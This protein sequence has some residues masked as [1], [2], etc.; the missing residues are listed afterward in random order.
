M[1]DP[2][3]DEIDEALWDEACRRAEASRGDPRI[4]D[5]SIWQG[6][7][8]EYGA[9]GC[10]TRSQSGNRIPSYQAI[11][12]WGNGNVAGERKPGRPDGSRVLDDK[13][14]EIIPTTINRY[15]LNKNRPSISQLIRDVQTGCVSAGLKPPHRRTI[16]TGLEDIDLQK[17]AKRRG[18]I[19]VVKRTTAVPGMLAAS[20]PL[21]IVQVDH[22]KADIFVV[23]EETRLP[24]GTNTRLQD[25]NL[26]LRGRR[27][28]ASSCVRL[29]L[30]TLASSVVLMLP[31][32]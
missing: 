31:T 29:A 28:P 16:E 24:I 9:A 14:D 7:S 17:R 6:S 27:L 12:K 23:D 21:H 30:F 4:S 25:K 26:V 2:L 20:R 13:G 32:K 8:R 5:A 15:Y 18:E 19:E 3:P 11:S 22:T 10:R 1:N